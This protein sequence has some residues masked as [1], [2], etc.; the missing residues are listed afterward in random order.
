MYRYVYTHRSI[1][2]E[3]R[4]QDSKHFMREVSKRRD[5]LIC[6]DR[7]L[8]S[9]QLTPYVCITCTNNPPLCPTP[10]FKT[11]HT[12]KDYNYRSTYDL[13]IY[14]LQYSI[15]IYTMCNNTSIVL[16][17]CVDNKPQL[18]VLICHLG[19]YIIIK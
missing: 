2:Q 17:Y 12:Q 18:I 4:L 16:F 14:N 9:R 1:Q 19:H 7:K 6:S 10:C 8:G 11:Y 3:Q 5:C 15:F 13:L